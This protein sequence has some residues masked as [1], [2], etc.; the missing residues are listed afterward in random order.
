LQPPRRALRKMRPFRRARKT[1]DLAFLAIFAGISLILF[2]GIW[3]CKNLNF[4]DFLNFYLCPGEKALPIALRKKTAN[5]RFNCKILISFARNF[6]I[7]FYR[8]PKKN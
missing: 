5:L 6:D 1:E 2:E 4:F 3:S 8:M 7:V